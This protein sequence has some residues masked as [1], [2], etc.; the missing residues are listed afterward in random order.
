M[1]YMPAVLKASC[2]LFRFEV[3]DAEHTWTTATNREWK[4]AAPGWVRQACERPG[5]LL[6]TGPLRLV[7]AGEGFEPS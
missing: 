2:Q 4:A 7:V 3:C 6:V 5:D 1:N